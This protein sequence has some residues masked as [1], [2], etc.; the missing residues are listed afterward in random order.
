MLVLSMREL[1]EPLMRQEEWRVSMQPRPRRQFL[2]VVVIAL[3][4]V[5]LVVLLR[6]K[7]ALGYVSLKQED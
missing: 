7:Q 4:V 2:Q 5:W 6:R 3:R 1:W